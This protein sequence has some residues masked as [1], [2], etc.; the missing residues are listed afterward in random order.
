VKELNKISVK[1]FWQNYSMSTISFSKHQDLPLKLS[2]SV[3]FN[4]YFGKLTQHNF[5]ILYESKI[6]LECKNCIYCNNPRPDV[7]ST[8]IGIINGQIN[9]LNQSQ[10]D[11]VKIIH[12]NICTIQS[13]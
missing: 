13:K 2:L 8:H 5:K 7:C 9:K 12:N 3:F 4:I 6:L 1:D 10:I 11:L